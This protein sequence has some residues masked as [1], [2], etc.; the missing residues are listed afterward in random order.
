[1][2]SEGIPYDRHPSEYIRL[3]KYPLSIYSTIEASLTD[4][5]DYRTIRLSKCPLSMYSVIDTIYCRTIDFRYVSR[6]LASLHSLRSAAVF[7]PSCPFQ[8]LSESVG[9][10][11]GAHFSRRIRREARP[12]RVI[13]Q[14]TNSLGKTFPSAP[15]AV[16]YPCRTSNTLS[17]HSVR[18][19]T[20]TKLLSTSCP[21]RDELRISRQ[22]ST[23]TTRHLPNK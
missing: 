10:R 21:F 2:L 11:L 5:F 1:M 23:I 9:T 17:L 7:L 4:I 14:K 13:K 6:T 19:S 22:L 16:R 3:S 12:D 8:R 18:L 15:V 20:G